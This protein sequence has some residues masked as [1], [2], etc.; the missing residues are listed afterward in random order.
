[1]IEVADTEN[2][3]IAR[4]KERKLRRFTTTIQLIGD[5]R[6]IVELIAQGESEMN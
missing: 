5:L 6:P 4:L 2:E 3:L 1:V